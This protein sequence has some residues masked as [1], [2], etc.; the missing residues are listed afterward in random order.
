MAVNINM[1]IEKVESNLLAFSLSPSPKNFEIKAPPPVPNIV[2]IV[3]TII[4]TGMIK[5]I[6][7]KASSPII[8]VIN[9]PSTIP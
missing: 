2:P 7:V 6:T 5:L 4:T 8:L 1:N 9:N 3:P